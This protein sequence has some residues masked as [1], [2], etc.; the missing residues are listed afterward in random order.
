MMKFV[1]KERIIQR[2][3]EVSS[4]HKGRQMST[5]TGTE[6][7]E[8]KRERRAYQTGGEPLG[9]GERRSEVRPR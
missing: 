4:N 3:T 6:T 5:T 2:Q 7:I 1:L 9:T 8:A